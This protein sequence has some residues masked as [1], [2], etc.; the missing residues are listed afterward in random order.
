RQPT[1]DDGI[2]PVVPFQT[3]RQMSSGLW[4]L[5][6]K[7]SFGLMFGSIWALVGGLITGVFLAVG[8]M[9]PLMWLFSLIPMLFLVVGLIVLGVALAKTHRDRALMLYGTR[10]MGRITS[11]Q[12]DTLVQVNR[13]H[14]THIRYTYHDLQGIEHSGSTHMFETRLLEALKPGREV[15]LLLDPSNPSRSVLPAATNVRF[16]A[17][18]I[19]EDTRPERLRS[20]E[21]PNPSEASWSGELT[22]VSSLNQARVGVLKRIWGASRGVVRLGGLHVSE[23]TRLVEHNALGQEVAGVEL[24]DPFAVSVV[25]WPLAYGLVEVSVSVRNRGAP[26]TTRS[27]SLKTQLPQER[28]SGQISVQQETGAWL[29]PADFDR[30][31]SL[32]QVHASL[33]GHDLSLQIHTHAQHVQAKAYASVP[34]SQRA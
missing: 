26:A 4:A 24:E 14:P 32:L 16:I 12:L 20:R 15:P 29:A 22:L 31:W 7:Y 18:A 11:S 10:V 19:A 2:I 33:Q 6:G 9:V 28:V 25:V 1:T 34:V 13:Q 23:G 3:P 5:F 27:V 17:P 8:F 21:A 30:L